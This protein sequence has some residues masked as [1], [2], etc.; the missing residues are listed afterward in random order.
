MTKNR[1]FQAL[2]LAGL[3]NSAFFVA[4]SALGEEATVLQPGKRLGL[5]IGNSSYPLSPVNTA[6][7]DAKAV[8]G[9]LSDGGFDV[10]YVEDARRVDIESAIKQFSQKL[11]GGDTAFVY[12]A[13]HAIQNQD[14]N[15]LVPIDATISSDADVRTQAVDV[16]LILDPLIVDRP[17]GGVI[18]LDAA[19]KNPWQQKTSTRASGLANVS[20]IHG[21][22]QAYP[23]SPG[24]VV[25]DQIATHGL[26]ATEFLR[27]AKVPGRTFKDAFHLTRTAVAKAN[28]NKEVP[29]ETSLDTA[30]FVIT[31]RSEP[32]SIAAGGIIASPTPDPLEQGFWET[33]K[34]SD[35]AANFQA[36]LDAYPNGAF[37]SAARARLQSVLLIGP[38]KPPTTTNAQTS[39]VQDCP[40]CPE[41]VLIPSGSFAMGSTELS[42]FESP[43]HQVTIRRS[44]YI[45]RYEVT[46]DEWD[47]CIADKGCTYRPDDRGAGR[48]RRPVTNVDW[49]D[50]K[51][52]LAWLSQKTGKTYRLPTES[53]WEYVA[54]ASTTSAYSWG[55]SIEKDRANCAGCTS[56]R[57]N[58]TIEVGSFKPN[59]FGVYDMAG[60]AA[61]WVEDCWSEGYR[62]A[63]DDGSASPKKGCP[64]R[65]LRGGAFNNDPK[66]V[67]SAARFRYDYDVRYSSNGFRVVR[68]Q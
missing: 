4:P 67:R 1:A 64:A 63:P 43:V 3:V 9:L 19:R 38:A 5:V 12:F 14:R 47:A 32:T 10:V 13:G 28:R 25:D 55:R 53:E 62:G 56:E 54:R 31:P 2:L 18:I 46:F 57:H 41:L 16:D 49:N 8:A 68:E 52:Y 37:A 20:P 29:W 42:D 50:A 27:T 6:I 40:Q 58:N 66:Y 21:I 51:A 22:T 45:G 17:K 15:F 65:V 61:E 30:D 11:E 34:N 44:F 7:A 26:F 23:A 35:S 36:Y 59:D 60:N 33:I 39:I 24:Q 48:G